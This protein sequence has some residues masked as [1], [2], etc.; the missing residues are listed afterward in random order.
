MGSLQF[1]NIGI[2]QIKKGLTQRPD[3]SGIMHL[4]TSFLPPTGTRRTSS[5][6]GEDKAL[7]FF[8]WTNETGPRDRVGNVKPLAANLKKLASQLGIAE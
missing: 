1:K 2:I 8:G 3:R 5:P 4:T 7:A 6:K